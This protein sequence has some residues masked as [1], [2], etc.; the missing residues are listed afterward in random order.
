[1]SNEAETQ[2]PQGFSKLLGQGVALILFG[3]A[4][5]I[6]I[7]YLGGSDTTSP[8]SA[9]NAS[10]KTEQAPVTTKPANSGDKKFNF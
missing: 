9:G 10:P 1:M 4:V 5:F 2:K 7:W 6:L 8:Q 3:F